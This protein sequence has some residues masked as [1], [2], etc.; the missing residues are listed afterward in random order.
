MLKKEGEH[1]SPKFRT[2]TSFL[3]CRVYS[4]KVGP[5]MDQPSSTTASQEDGVLYNVWSFGK[6]H[7][8]ACLDDKIILQLQE[9]NT[10]I[11]VMTDTL[12]RTNARTAT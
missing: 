8:V 4:E 2:Q 9:L 6:W 5:K 1:P 12:W 7:F 3:I 10:G 11:S